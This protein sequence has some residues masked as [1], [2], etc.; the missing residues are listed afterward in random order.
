[1]ITKSLFVKDA[2]LKQIV[3]TLPVNLCLTS[4]KEMAGFY[5]D[6]RGVE[7]V[8]ASMYIPSM[9][10][11][12]LI[13]IDKDEVLAPI[14]YVLINALITAVVVIVMIVLLFIGFIKKMVTPLRKISEASKKIASG[15]FDVV[16]PV[17]TH[18][19][20]GVLCESFNY[21]T[22]HI[23]S[24]TTALIRS[25]ARLAEAQRI[26]QIG[27]WEWDVIK[28]EVSWSCEAHRIFG[29]T[30][31][32][33][34]SPFET[35]LNHVH[36]EDRAFVKKSVD[37]TLANKKPFDIDHR[38]LLKDTTIRIVHEKAVVISDSKGRAIQMVGTV[39]DITERKRAEA[40]VVLLKTLTLSISES[41]D[42]HDALIVTLENVCS[43]TGWVYGEAWIPDPE[44]KCLVRDHAF[45]S[46][47]DTLEKFS[48][49]SGKVTFSF[50]MGL[51]G[52][53]WSIKKPVWVQ[54]VTLDPNYLRAL[55]ARESGLKAGVAFPVFSGEE[56][57]AVLVFYMFEAHEKSERF[58]SFVSSVLVQLGEVIKRKKAETAV[59][60]RSL[61]TALSADVG[62]ALIQKSTLRESL[63]LCAD[64]LVLNLNAAFARI[65]TL[66]KAENVLELQSSAGIYTHIDGPH[67]RVPVGMYKIGLIAEEC[68]PHLTNKV[69]GDPRIHNQEWAK[70]TGMVAFAGY[71]LMIEN[72]LV[73]VMAIFARQPLTEFTL[74]ALAFVSD[75]IALGIERKHIEETKTRLSEIT[76]T[77]TDFVGT[78]T[79]DGRVLYI[80]KA[81][82]KIIGIG[83]NEDISNLRISDCHPKW[84]SDLILSEGIPDAIREGAW[85][86][87]TAFLSRDGCEI[88]ISQVIIAHKNPDGTVRNF[89]TIGRDITERK[90]F[91]TQIMHMANRDPLTN[92]LNRRRFHEELEGWL[93]QTR[94]F[95]IKGALLFLDL[96]N[97]KYINDSLGHQAGDKLLITIAGLLRERLRDTDI[98][99]RLGGDEFAIILPHAEVGLAE[100]V[101]NQ[102][103]ELVQYRTSLEGNYSAGIT[104]SIG[105]AMFPGHGDTVET[106]LTYAD[107]AMYRAKEEGRNRICVYTPEQKTQIESRLIWEKRIREALDQDRFVLFLQPIMD[108][109]QNLIIGQELLLRMT[110]EKGEIVSP[111]NFLDIAERFGL[112]HDIDRWVVSTAIPL[113]KKLQHDGKPTCLEVNLSGKAFTDKKLLPLIRSELA[114]TGIDPVNIIFEITETSIIENIDIARHFIVELKSLGCR[115]A[116]DDFG[117]GFSSLNYIKHLPVDYLKIDGSFV[118]N[119]LYD[120]VD[121]HLVKAMVE[122]ARGLGK[123]TIA[124]FVENEE[125]LH[126]LREYGIDYAQGYHIG[127][128]RHVSEL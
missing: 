97:F 29:L 26:A 34:V 124:E 87:E 114:A 12:L 47:V 45:F 99:A 37:D 16:V 24:R 9:K 41:K 51:P 80:N 107:L 67:S 7:V 125:T 117:I 82:R 111:S 35:F 13:E 59:R 69:I 31:E 83:E 120:T 74:K 84:A 18:D 94:R 48:E 119:L 113:I 3:D 46:R 91:E 98:L 122:V 105:V 72:R 19:E 8:G 39:Q 77:T 100:S 92:L 50:G 102:I 110:N 118:R 64:A 57:V 63:Q 116:L 127:K 106:L 54:D 20:I 33:V 25:E 40:E 103:R 15:N 2:I 11:V 1:M 96:D 79:I 32:S 21:M 115:F 89:S 86:G 27:N 28:N 121:Q 128:P 85:I 88:A 53:A 55:I 61:L 123:K 108:I 49:L 109:H 76:E 104:V 75:V 93:A 126:L 6:Y 60:E 38:I 4:N 66:N 73:G 65:W 14:R 30:Q 71:P 17:Q 68:K 78:T 112:I 101:A 36:H 70:Q 81:G 5:K 44:G 43:A 95:G 52:R 62:F 23:K 22:D 90:R 42:L 10:W 58:V 56:I